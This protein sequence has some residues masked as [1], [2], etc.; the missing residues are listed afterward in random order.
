MN[1]KETLRILVSRFKAQGIDFV[2]S[3]G[4]SFEKQDGLLIFKFSS[5]FFKKEAKF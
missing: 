3:G 5:K 1:L 2:L 4:E